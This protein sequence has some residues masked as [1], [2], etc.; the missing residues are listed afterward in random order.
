VL[1]INVWQHFDT[2][3]IWLSL[4]IVLVSIFICCCFFIAVKFKLN[5]DLSCQS[6]F[7]KYLFPL[8]LGEDE[9]R[10]AVLLVFANKQDLP[11]A[12]T[13]SEITDK[14]GLST[15]RNKTVSNWPF[16]KQLI[17]ILGW[18]LSVSFTNKSDWKVLKLMHK[19][20]HVANGHV[21]VSIL[22]LALLIWQSWTEFKL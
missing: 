9:L 5:D 14:L 17:F 7:Y 1:H 3:V 4:N 10:D 15:L 16:S 18:P 22:M 2:G 21:S 11:N 8:Q 13:S 19:W 6:S 12:M 20:L